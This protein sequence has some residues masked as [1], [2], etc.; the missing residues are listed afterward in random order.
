M[1]FFRDILKDIGNRSWDI[2]RLCALWAVFSY[3]FAFLWAL[4]KLG[5]VPDWSSLGIGYAAVLAGA[6]AFVGGK[7][8]ANA[9]A[10]ATNASV[11][12]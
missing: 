11:A 1:R 5:K 12:P 9:K 2:A 7:D 4:I 3:S 6:V 10:N 8:I